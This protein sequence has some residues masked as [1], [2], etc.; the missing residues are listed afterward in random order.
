LL[1]FAIFAAVRA[2]NELAAAAPL[3][4][5]MVLLSPLSWKAYYVFM[6]LPVA[7]MVSLMKTAGKPRYVIAAALAVT[8]GLF[9]LTSPRVIGLA[10]AEWADAH[11]LVLA[12]AFLIFAACVASVHRKAIGLYGR[13]SVGAPS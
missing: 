12:G 10:A 6:L 4:C 13:P 2:Q 8:F 5:C 1:A 3:F 7:R 11:S 9:N